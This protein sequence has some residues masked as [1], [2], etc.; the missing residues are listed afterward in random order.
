MWIGQGFSRRW[1]RVAQ[2]SGCDAW[3][4]GAFDPLA[5]EEQGLDAFEVPTRYVASGEDEGD[6]REDD[7]EER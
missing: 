3:L 1:R 7:E 5:Q 4:R 2:P 6:R